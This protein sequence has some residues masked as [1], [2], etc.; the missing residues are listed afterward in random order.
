MDPS[1]RA[2]VATSYGVDAEQS[3][4]SGAGMEGSGDQVNGAMG[5]TMRPQNS[6]DFPDR[7][8]ERQ[9][10]GLVK[11]E[12][13]NGVP[14]VGGLGWKSRTGHLLK[15][16]TYFANRPGENMW[17]NPTHAGPKT[18]R[19]YHGP[20][21]RTD[22]NL[23]ERLDVLETQQAEWEAKKAFVNTVRVQT[24][25]RLYHQKVENEQKEM[26][27]QWAPHRRARGER[28]K[29]HESLAA[30]LDSMPM[31]ELKKVLTST[32]LR[33]DREAIRNITKRIQTEET[34]KMA[35][36]QVEQARRE[37]ILSD[38]EHRQTY[39]AMLMELAGQPGRA[40]NPNRRIPNNASPRVEELAQPAPPIVPD[41]ITKR[42]D[43]A[44]L[45]HVD[46]RHALEARF[47][48]YG[49]QLACI[50]TDDATE[51][52]KP[53]W[54]PPDPSVT[55]E[56]SPKNRK[57]PSSPG[58][59]LVDI[60]RASVPVNSDRL[61]TVGRRQDPLVLTDH[62]T[63]QFLPLSAPPAPEQ[64]RSLLK[65]PVANDPAHMSLE[66]PPR[67]D[68][69]SMSLSVASFRSK[70]SRSSKIDITPPI[71]S[72]YYPVSVK[73][74][75]QQMADPN[76][77]PK[78]TH[79]ALATAT[80]REMERSRK[81]AEKW[82]PI[83][84]QSVDITVSCAGGLPRADR[85]GHSDPYVLVEVPEKPRARIKTSVINDSENPIWNE[86]H[87]LRGWRR[88]ELLDLKVYDY[89]LAGNHDL[90]AQVQIP[91]EQFYPDGFEGRIE[92]ENAWVVD[93]KMEDEVKRYN[94]SCR[95]FIDLRIKVRADVWMGDTGTRELEHL[96]S[97]PGAEPSCGAVCSH[98][99]NFEANLK[100]VPR[101]GNFWMTPR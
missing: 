12:I 50:L 20:K 36:K 86:D 61:S 89:D 26:A 68:H 101:L 76:W 39:N 99:D 40:R 11:Y 88:G 92:M 63:E 97:M 49:H 80:P 48:A 87:V 59:G 57:A 91:S 47:P 77:R 46:N 60:R 42:T 95:P 100:P 2:A 64:A 13:E 56:P 72:N 79:Q 31:K 4:S 35:W 37:E 67:S 69:T 8:D 44:G 34:W 54:P 74:V 17:N 71:R 19:S 1:P 75:E 96:V 43:Y 16:Q 52:A 98:L 6:L 82:P 38:F 83:G 66:L 33:G 22:A 62:A 55:P 65:E 18:W 41:D 53:G 84:S 5:D 32:V 15:N 73:A 81:K 85:G 27:S 94:L 10:R 21:L 90:L 93:R 45:V 23:M 25:D 28:H 58:E 29:V 70:D 9:R 78:R 7:R 51:R 14:E 24:L 30:E 3:Y